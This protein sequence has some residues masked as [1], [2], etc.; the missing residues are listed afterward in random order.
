MPDIR[1]ANRYIKKIGQLESI[2]IRD[3]S[4]IH[5][6]ARKAML[7]IITRD[8]VR[9]STITR[10]QEEIDRVGRESSQIGKRLS[11]IVDQTV[12]ENVEQQI[13]TLKKVGET[14][15]PS[16]SQGQILTNTQRDQVYLSI[17]QQIPQ[18]T[19]DM[20]QAIEINMTRLVVA[21][22]DVNTAISRLLATTIMDGRASVW[23]IADVAMEKQTGLLTWTAA[24]L[25]GRILYNW[26][27]QSTKTEYKKQAVATIDQVTTDCCL[28]VHGQIQ[29]LNE[30]FKLEGE[31]RFADEV[32]SPP[33]HWYCRTAV[34][35]YTEKLEERGVPTSEMIEAARLEL[36]ARYE[37]GRRELIQP[38]N[39]ISR[40]GR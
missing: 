7:D 14:G 30:P 18:W 11:A 28:R 34:V 36:K 39:A 1:L 21:G 8:G 27:N 32:D 40:R 26:L 10:L 17:M 33:F 19:V 35:L 5:K 29:P 24:S 2:Y 16:V 12:V 6:E 25:S 20:A 31:P 15:L 13:A 37:T 22:A 3:V 9:Y 38:S 4:S 23:R